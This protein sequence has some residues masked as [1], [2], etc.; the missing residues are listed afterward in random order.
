[1]RRTLLLILAVLA[2]ASFWLTLHSTGSAGEE[3]YAWLEQRIGLGPEVGGNLAVLEGDLE[4]GGG[5]ELVVG[6]GSGTILLFSHNSTSITEL[7]RSELLDGAVR[8]LATADLNGDDLTDIVAVTQNGQIAVFTIYDHALVPLWKVTLDWPALG[9]IDLQTVTVIDSTIWIGA[10][11]DIWTLDG[12]SPDVDGDGLLTPADE[13]EGVYEH[14]HFEGSMG[15]IGLA[16]GLSSDSRPLLLLSNS[17]GLWQL[18]DGT[19]EHLL[20]A[21]PDS[22]MTVDLVNDDRNPDAILL[23]GDRILLVRGGTDAPHHEV[24]VLAEKEVVLARAADGRILSFNASGVLELIDGESLAIRASITLQTEL[25][26]VI[27]TPYGVIVTTVQGELIGLKTTGSALQETYRFHP[28]FGGPVHAVLAEEGSFTG[29]ILVAGNSGRIYRLNSDLEVVA[30]SQVLPAG[31]IDL[32]EGD[33]DSD[34]SVELV[35]LLARTTEEQGGLAILDRSSL[36]LETY[37][38]P[39]ALGLGLPRSLALANLDDDLFTELVIIEQPS[40]SS[41]G[42]IY[43]GRLTILQYNGSA[44]IREYRTTPSLNAMGPLQL[45]DIEGDGRIEIV[46]STYDSAV[47]FYQYDS[48]NGYEL[49]LTHLALPAVGNDLQLV[50]LDGDS[51]LELVVVTSIGQAQSYDHTSEGYQLDWSSSLFHSPLTAVEIAK[52]DESPD[53][54]LTLSTEDGELFIYDLG[55]HLRLFQARDLGTNISSLT[56]VGDRLLLTTLGEMVS[57]HINGDVAAKADLT[58]DE[59]AFHLNPHN[60][61][62]GQELEV[63]VRLH[64]RGSVGSVADMILYLGDPTREGIELARLTSDDPV[65]AH[66]FVDLFFTLVLE[67]VGLQPIY[68]MAV[69]H[70]DESELSN[71]LAWVEILVFPRRLPDL[72]FGLHSLKL[73]SGEPRVADDLRVTVDLY[74]VGTLVSQPTTVIFQV[75]TSDLLVEERRYDISS[76]ASKSGPYPLSFGW[77]ATILG[78]HI[79]RVQVDPDD[80]HDELSRTNNLL[81]RQVEVAPERLPDLVLDPSDLMVLHLIHNEGARYRLL[82]YLENQGELNSGPFTPMLIV[83]GDRQPYLGDD[84]LPGLKP[85]EG[86]YLETIWEFYTPGLHTI[87]FMADGYLEIRESSETNN[88]A[89]TTVTVDERLLRP[90]LVL[91]EIYQLEEAYVGQ[92]V[93][94]TL[95]ITNQGGV[96]GT[97]RLVVWVDDIA[98]LPLPVSLGPGKGDYFDFN[99]TSKTQGTHTLIVRVDSLNPAD[100]DEN[101]NEASAK[102]MVSSVQEPEQDPENASPADPQVSASVIVASA[103]LSLAL[104]GGLGMTDWGRYRYLALFGPLY[105]RIRKDKV[106]DHTTREAIFNYISANP[107]EH[108]RQLATSTSLPTGTLIHHLTTLE[109]EEYVK[110][111]R[112][113]VFKRFYPFGSHLDATSS[114]LGQPQKKVLAQL[115]L[116]PGISPTELAKALDMSRQRIHYHLRNLVSD[117]LVR[118]ERDGP[119]S[120]KCFIAP[121]D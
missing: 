84:D 108:L 67:E 64:N 23:E 11:N 7:D 35:A 86:I 82:A 117:G 44:W 47:E 59:G 105:S 50:N 61:E 81:E 21:Q 94:M 110:S 15:Q 49:A 69:A 26:N 66:G 43:E 51:A 48:I 113:G 112:D 111:I 109:R 27:A 72:A 107:G 101:D 118:L 87:G 39:G 102:V 16:S 90:D 57:I 53:P 45:G 30:W 70:D 46:L 104:A 1:M 63:K 38:G 88:E 25:H 80:L 55:D 12:L 58:L 73:N 106:L 4:T 41:S 121:K 85:G 10:Q 34:G 89:T 22:Q 92:M 74:N 114:R 95:F 93:N 68:G 32:A 40:S 76:L 24:A 56:S 3:G 65:P 96:T 52:L 42:N 115:E 119:R 54:R 37:L 100:L 17:S 62:Q 71:N 13:P 83:D 79:L 33:L 116:E 103:G 91:G 14:K 6:T 36:E 60:V 29:S 98:Q 2:V 18:D 20:F 97:G 19:W 5:R 8:S 99:F 75:F 28:T 9:V 78:T 31:V 77:K 120:V